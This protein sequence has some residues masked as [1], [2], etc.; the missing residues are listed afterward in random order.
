[1]KTFLDLQMNE[2]RWPL[3]DTLSAPRTFCAAPKAGGGSPYC[4]RHRA[5]AYVPAPKRPFR[6]P[7]VFR[8][9]MMLEQ[10]EPEFDEV[11]L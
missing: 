11:L 2:C 5:M 4:A 7:R 8:G 3:D 6:E 9:P 1:M 10:I